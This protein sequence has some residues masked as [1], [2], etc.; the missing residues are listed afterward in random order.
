ME[1]VR[2]VAQIVLA[3]GVL[4]VWLLRRSKTTP[5]RGGTAKTLPEEFAVYGL[6]HW[7]MVAVGVIKVTVSLALIAGIWLPVLVTP[8]AYILTVLMLAALIMH[9]K[10]KDVPQK[11]LPA[12]AMITLCLVVLWL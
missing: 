1:I 8:A 7:F 6:P 2:I 10:V 3:L 9:V 4:N 5:Y 12:L 11:S